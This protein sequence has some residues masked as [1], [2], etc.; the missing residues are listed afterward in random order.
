VTKLQ[1]TKTEQYVQKSKKLVALS[2]KEKLEAE[3][4]SFMMQESTAISTLGEKLRVHRQ[5]IDRVLQFVV[6]KD[7]AIQE[8]IELEQ[9][10]ISGVDDEGKPISD[11]SI[12]SQ[13]QKMLKSKTVRNSDLLRLVIIFVGCYELTDQDWNVITKLF[14]ESENRHLIENLKLL[15]AGLTISPIKK[16]RR[17][18]PQITQIELNE[19]NRK[20]E[21]IDRKYDVLRSTPQISKIATAAQNCALDTE[22]YPFIDM[23]PSYHGGGKKKKKFGKANWKFQDQEGQAKLILFV[24]GGLSYYEVS[25]LQAMGESVIV[26]GATE[27]IRPNQILQQVSQLDEVK[28]TLA[29]AKKEG[30]SGLMMVDSEDEDI[31]NRV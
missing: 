19:Y 1:E 22:V 27:L 23:P 20:L 2:K 28:D 14:K 9:T 15:R 21:E 11:T 6:E 18:V 4:I 24:I 25:V 8:I 13:L 31:G 29:S 17:K 16:M 10:I 30:K 26:P 3:E 12:V 7:L 5:L